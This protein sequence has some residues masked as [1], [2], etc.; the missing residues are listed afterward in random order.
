MTDKI[1]EGG[2]ACGLARFSVSGDPIFVNNCHCKQ[3]QN[4]TGGTSVVNLF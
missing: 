2:C 3:C 1:R 4:Q